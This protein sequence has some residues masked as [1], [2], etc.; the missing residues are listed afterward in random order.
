MRRNRAVARQPIGTRLSGPA[1]LAR[2]SY[3]ALRALADTG[4]Y[5]RA[6]TLA[7]P[8]KAPLATA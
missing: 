7:L 5:A 4:A 8:Y 6:Q 3:P 1:P 2:P